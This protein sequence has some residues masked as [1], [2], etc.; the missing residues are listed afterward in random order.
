M[1]FVSL[2]HRLR[3]LDFET[4]EVIREAAKAGDSEAQYL[5]GTR[6]YFSMGDNRECARWLR[7]AAK[8]GHPE[9]NFYLFITWF[10]KGWRIYTREG[11]R[12][13][14]K[15][16]RR[17]LRAVE[18]GSPS[19]QCRLGHYLTANRYG[20][21]KDW[22][23]ARALYLQAASG[24]NAEAQSR[25]GWMMVLGE[26]GPVEKE[27]GFALLEEVAHGQHTFHAEHAADL[28]AALYS[29][30][31][32]LPADP[33]KAG[34]WVRE[35][36][37]LRE[38]R[39]SGRAFDKLVDQLHQAAECNELEKVRESLLAG[40]AVD[41][42]DVGWTPLM[43]AARR[44][45]IEVCQLLLENGA[46]VDKAIN[47][48]AAGRTRRTPDLLRLFIEHNC[49]IQPL[50]WE[51]V[52]VGRVQDALVVL[53][54]GADVNQP[55]EKGYPPLLLAT[56]NSPGMIRLLLQNGA[57]PQQCSTPPIHSLTY[58]ATF[59]HYGRLKVLLE[60][61][62]PCAVLDHALVV[63]C[64]VGH[65]R[66]ARALMDAGAN[67]NPQEVTPLMA[68]S[69]QGSLALVNLLLERGADPH[70][71]DNEGKTALDYA[72][73]YVDGNL[74]DKAVSRFQ[75][76]HGRERPASEA[77]GSDSSMD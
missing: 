73:S 34:Q 51:A 24:G 68:A 76:A 25:A 43:E 69:D 70:R 56:L 3:E 44:A 45:H 1:D 21:K 29:G 65:Y 8:Q 47:V 64:G 63:A 20:F 66:C 13:G 58:C 15:R 67:P 4:W 37:R 11:G 23:K 7:A 36:E 18:L 53:Q 38:R 74:Q 16:R 52:R 77:L 59:G 60:A 54:A 50:F 26:G 22:T 57:D 6:V 75:L 40:V 35:K 28:L 2:R 42:I 72:L 39:N 17:L 62:I 31:Y 61:R 71:K 46:E 19:A 41:S 9:A 30:R 10:D 49:P 55:N 48:A 5:M 33:D 14:E 32:G 12:I 27:A